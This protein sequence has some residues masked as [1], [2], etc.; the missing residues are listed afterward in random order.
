MSGYA[1]LQVPPNS[2]HLWRYTP[3][4]RVH[5]TS[6]EE[7]PQSES[8]RFSLGEQ[9]ET[10]DVSNEIARAFISEL[11]DS[12]THL[13]LGEGHHDLD[14]R[15]AGHICSGHLHIESSSHASLVIRLSGEPGWCGLR[16]TGEVAKNS[17]L[18]IA[19]LNELD[20]NAVFLRCEDW[21]VARDSTLEFSTLSI[22]GLRLKSDIRINLLESGSETRGAFAIHGT[23][24]R[25]DDHHVEIAHR[26]GHTTSSLEIHA[27]CD[28]SSHSV[29]T[30]LL[31][32][33]EAADGSDAGQVF[34]NILLSE[35]ARAESIPEL[36]V[37]AHEVSAAHGAA[38][39]PI[40]SEQLHY[41]MSRGLSP[42]DA[43]STIVEGFLL[44]AFKDIRSSAIID[45]IRT[46]LLVHLGCELI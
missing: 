16:I 12:T 34:R 24:P 44:D 8:I 19:L 36:E 21:Q 31:T 20:S 17:S 26:V 11:T 5:P 30:G 43:T 2:E 42:E 35:K 14:A 7:I 9:R 3:W 32:I 39:G 23:G 10:S 22:G 41:L 15:A 38:S 18:S 29:A 33:D 4:K 46:R 45:A 37:K 6:I 1:S 28:D 27:A 25:H 40:D 13:S